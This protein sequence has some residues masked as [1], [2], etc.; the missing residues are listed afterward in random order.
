MIKAI[1]AVYENGVLRPTEALPL[2]EHERV[3]VTISHWPNEDWNDAEFVAACAA[4]A[5]PSITLQ[6]VRTALS[7]IQGSMDDAISQGRGEY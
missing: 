4:D 2:S 5:D 7:K 3:R 6:Q 1:D